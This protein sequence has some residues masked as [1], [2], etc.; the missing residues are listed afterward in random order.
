L[1][2]AAK[3]V[4]SEMTH[5]QKMKAVIESATNNPNATI[6]LDRFR[7]IREAEGPQRIPSVRPSHETPKKR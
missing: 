3:K 7:Q 5:A 6:W 2:P 4:E 1:L